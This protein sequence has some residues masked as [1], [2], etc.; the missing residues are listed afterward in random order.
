MVFKDF[1]GLLQGRT[2][3][4]PVQIANQWQK[5]D[6]WQLLSWLQTWLLDIARLQAKIKLPIEN[7][8]YQQ[9]IAILAGS[10]EK[11]AVFEYSDKLSA[12]KLRIAQVNQIN[13][14]LALEELLIDLCYDRKPN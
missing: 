10:F 2:G 4:D 8:K 6:I 7:A 9:A 13:I 5:Y 1:V 3:V 12:L 11:N 14:Q